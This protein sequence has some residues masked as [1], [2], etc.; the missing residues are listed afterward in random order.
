MNIKKC[1]VWIFC[2]TVV[3]YPFYLAW[4]SAGLSVWIKGQHERCTAMGG[5]GA[6]FEKKYQCWGWQ[7]AA[8]IRLQFNKATDFKARS[9]VML[10]EAEYK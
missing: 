6:Y 4:K 2:L 5:Q 7:Q 9:K 10:F 8:S 1:L 3:P